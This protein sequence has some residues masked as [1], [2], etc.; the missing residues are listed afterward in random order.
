MDNIYQSILL[1]HQEM[2]S[3]SVPVLVSFVNSLDKKIKYP[4]KLFHNYTKIIQNFIKY[5]FRRKEDNWT[6][7]FNI[8]NIYKPIHV[9]FFVK[10]K[11]NE[12]I[13]L[14]QIINK[15]IDIYEDITPGSYYYNSRF[16][17]GLYLLIKNLDKQYIN[18][19]VNF[20]QIK[21]ILNNCTYKVDKIKYF[22]EHFSSNKNFKTYF[23]MIL[24]YNIINDDI[25]SSIFAHTNDLDFHDII[26]K[27]ILDYEYNFLPEHQCLKYA[28]RYSNQDRIMYA[29][30]YKFKPANDCLEARY[31]YEC[32][33]INCNYHDFKSAKKIINNI[34]N[35]FEL[36]IDFGF[37]PDYTTV[38]FFACYNIELPNIERFN[39]IIDDNIYQKFL[40]KNKNYKPLRYKFAMNP[41]KIFSQI[42]KSHG[43]F[44][45]YKNFFKINK[46]YKIKQED[47]YNICNYSRS[48]KLLSLLVDKGGIIDFK[49]L[50]ILTL[51][52][53]RTKLLFNGLKFYEEQF[54]TEIRNY[55]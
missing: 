3:F 44:I 47:M 28:C 17:S 26:N 1:G 12:M 18:N 52:I 40:I 7:I 46:N 50:K 45:T 8:Y 55:N 13:K 11:A 31:K 15:K 38:K 42:I 54:H 24:N 37:V 39:I 25:V 19:T 48:Q 53:S 21:Y 29:L 9:S 49:C 27:I 33:Q 14:L 34:F 36:F 5:D 30:N 6:D 23:M 35:I 2:Y 20:E 4:D 16:S 41:D 10:L 32:D 43:E 22:I 51:S